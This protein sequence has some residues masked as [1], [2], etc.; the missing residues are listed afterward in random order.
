MRQ[1]VEHRAS[2][3][4]RLLFRIAAAVTEFSSSGVVFKVDRL[5]TRGSDLGERHD[6]RWVI[7]SGSSSSTKGPYLV[8]QW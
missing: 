6:L 8:Y 5:V 4:V 2:Y 3:F 7:T 1:S